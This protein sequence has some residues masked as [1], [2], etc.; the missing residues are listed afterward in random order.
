MYPG[1]EIVAVKCFQPGGD[2]LLHVGV[3]RKS[4][5][6][7]QLFN[8]CKGMLIA[9][10]CT[11]NRAYDL[12]RRHVWKVMN[13]PRCSPDLAPSD[14]HPFGPIKKRLPGKRFATEYM[15]VVL[16]VQEDGIV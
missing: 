9:G 14:C 7:R 2:T 4:F 10:P 13:H 1:V 3:C 6:S 12:L 15:Y 8:V 5:V 16:Y 11:A